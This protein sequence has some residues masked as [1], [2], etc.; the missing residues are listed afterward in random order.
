MQLDNVFSALEQWAKKSAEPQ[1]SA[2]SPSPRAEVDRGV[3][4]RL[5]FVGDSTMCVSGYFIAEG[6]CASLSQFWSDCP[7][8]HVR[9]HQSAVLRIERD[10]HNLRYCVTLAMTIH[11]VSNAIILLPTG[12]RTFLGECRFFVDVFSWVL[13]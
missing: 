2:M 3:T 13:G 10:E 6:E 8:Q 4:L 11:H 7:L 5:A 1:E 9:S 12:K